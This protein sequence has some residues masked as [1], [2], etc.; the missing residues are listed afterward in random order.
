VPELPAPAT[1]RSNSVRTDLISPHL[2]AFQRRGPE[3]GC[4]RD[5]RRVSASGDQDA[6]D[7]GRIVAGIE[8]VPSVAEIGLEPGRKVH[9]RIGWR[10]ADIAEIASAVTRRDIQTTA[11]RDGQMGKV[12]THALAIAGTERPARS[13]LE[14][15]RVT[16]LARVVKFSYLILALCVPGEKAGRETCWVSPGKRRPDGQKNQ[17]AKTVSRSLPPPQPGGKS[18]GP[19]LTI[20]N[21]F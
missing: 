3:A 6:P 18:S 10:H 4:E 16:A 5:I 20:S 8:G 19:P 11:E 7:A 17:T 2:E 21:N 9:G 15:A 12:A 13:R 1:S 14:S